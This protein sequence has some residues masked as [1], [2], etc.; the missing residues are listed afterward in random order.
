M[1]LPSP[2]VTSQPVGG[3]AEGRGRG[4]EAAGEQG[5]RGGH[6]GTG[7]QEDTGCG[8]AGIGADQSS[9][10]SAPRDIQVQA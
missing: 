8:W 5:E 6:L 9:N 2:Q 1:T 10:W 3:Q 4:S 7:A